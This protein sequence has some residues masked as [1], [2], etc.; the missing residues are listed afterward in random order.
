[1]PTVALLGL[2]AGCSAID[3]DLSDCGPEQSDFELNYQL[4]LVTNM[5]TE[6]QTQLS[7]ITETSIASS[8]ET[9]LKGIFS[10]YAR[11]VNLSFY[12]AEGDLRRLW[13]DRQTMNANQRSYTLT[14]PMHH[15]LHLAV[16]NLQ[17]NGQ[18]SLTDDEMAPTSA[19]RQDI[20]AAANGPLASHATGLFTA[21]QQMN[22]LS[23]VSQTFNVRLYMANCAAA[24]VID[25]RGHSYKDIRVVATGFASQFNVSDSSYVFPSEA[26]QV[27]AEPLDNGTDPMLGF[28]SV[29]FPSRDGT[30]ADGEGPLWQFKVYLKKTDDSI[31]ET[32][33]NV[34]DPLKAGQ[35]KVIKGYLDD[36]GA[37][38]S[39][40]QRVGISITLDWNNAGEHDFIL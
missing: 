36:D 12:D 25:P 38:R 24:L 30:R 11:D 31:T 27:E 6:L 34:S 18:V 17:G 33:L 22:V 20:S 1:M 5:T 2:L 26:F 29:N 15:Y 40:D 10:D 21:R 35:L 3:D 32:V 28:C 9:H 19:L 39:T 13:L 8:L 14:L 23:G 7:A 16:A 37:V 4:K